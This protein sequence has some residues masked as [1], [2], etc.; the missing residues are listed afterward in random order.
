MPAVGTDVV[1]VPSFPTPGTEES[2]F[3]FERFFRGAE[4]SRPGGNQ[5]VHLGQTL[6]ACGYAIKEATIKAL[7]S[8]RLFRSTTDKIDYRDLEVLQTRYDWQLRLHGPVASFGRAQGLIDPRIQLRSWRN[9]VWATVCFCRELEPGHDLWLGQ[10]ASPTTHLA[11][12]PASQL[13]QMLG[14]REW[15]YCLTASDNLRLQ[16]VGARLAA[17]RAV[18]RALNRAG[19]NAGLCKGLQLGVERDT[20]GRPFLTPAPETEQLMMEHGFTG[21][22]ISLSHDENLAVASAILELNYAR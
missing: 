5:D 12:L 11:R 18:V 17:R 21:A 13:A 20:S 1:F 10:A 7:E 14:S 8:L 9:F 19:V 16:R 4:L 22:R 15:Q 3:F 6:A 2:A